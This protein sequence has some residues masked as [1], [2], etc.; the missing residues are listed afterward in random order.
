M[1]VH[2]LDEVYAWVQ[3]KRRGFTEDPKEEISGNQ[4]FRVREASSPCYYASRGRNF[5]YS[6]SFPP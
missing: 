6:G 5:S 2:I 4:E 1:K 3:K